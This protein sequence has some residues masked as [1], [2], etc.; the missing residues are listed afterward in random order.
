MFCCVACGGNNKLDNL[1][2]NHI[3]SYKKKFIYV[4]E[5][6]ELVKFKPENSLY[7]CNMKRMVC[8]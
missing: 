2:D 7:M 4:Y 5:N 1:N 6:G 8:E 3:S